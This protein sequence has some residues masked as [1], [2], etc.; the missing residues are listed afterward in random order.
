MG[1]PGASPIASY[2][3][4][5]YLRVRSGRYTSASHSPDGARTHVSMT[6][7]KTFLVYFTLMTM[8]SDGHEQITK[9]STAM[10]THG[11]IE[12]HR[13]VVNHFSISRR[14]ISGSLIELIPVA[15][16]PCQGIS[17]YSMFILSMQ[18]LRVLPLYA[19]GNRTQSHPHVERIA[20]IAICLCVVALHLTTA[21]QSALWMWA[22]VYMCRQ[23]YVSN[24]H[25]HE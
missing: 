16:F 5:V 20:S 6:Q 14:V 22:I 3:D 13:Q 21:I 4:F 19:L 24:V 12:N 9:S 23:K 11:Q 7:S 10:G 25:G 1:C 17:V 15:H 8:R 2:K 18:S